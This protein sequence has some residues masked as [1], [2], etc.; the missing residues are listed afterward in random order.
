MKPGVWTITYVGVPVISK[1]PNKY[2]YKVKRSKERFE[3]SL[4][5]VHICVLAGNST[6]SNVMVLR[7]SGRVFVTAFTEKGMQPLFLSP[8]PSCK[9]T[10]LGIIPRISRWPIY[11]KS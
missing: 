9:L 5:F 10:P 3:I 4:Q 11:E 1:S 8:R 2:K 6:Y 7:T